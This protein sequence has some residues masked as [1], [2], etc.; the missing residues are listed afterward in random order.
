M[1]N[2]YSETHK[3]HFFRT[4]IFSYNDNTKLNNLWDNSGSLTQGTKPRNQELHLTDL[5]ANLV[6]Q[7]GVVLT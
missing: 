1:D 7:L 4:M 6:T 2:I 3:L 5:M